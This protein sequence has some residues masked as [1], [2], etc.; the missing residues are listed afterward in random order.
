MAKQN[1]GILLGKIVVLLPFS[2]PLEGKMARTREM[3]NEA[4]KSR[5]ENDGFSLF[6]LHLE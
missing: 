5:L 6:I 2:R 4:R 3:Q 1:K